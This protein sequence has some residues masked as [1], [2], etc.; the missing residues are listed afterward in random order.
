[1]AIR[2]ICW[3]SV[4][5]LT[6]QWAS[7]AGAVN[8]LR[9]AI[10][11]DDGWLTCFAGPGQEEMPGLF[12]PLW[13]PVRIPHNWETYQGYRRLSHGNLHGSAWYSRV[14]TPRPEDRGKRHFVEF[15]GVGSYATVWI[16][17]HRLGEHAGGR[18]G[19]SF[20]LTEHLRFGQPNLLAVHARHPEKIDDLPYVCG[21]CWGSPNTEGSQPLGI[22]RP[23]KLLV[24]APVRIEPLGVHVWTPQ[25]S[26]EEAVARVNT[27]V[28]NYGDA[29][30]S[31]T[32]RSEIVDADGT[33]LA[34]MEDAVN[35]ALG[36]MQCVEQ[37]SP[38]IADP[39]LWSLDDP[40]LHHV[41]STIVEDGAT[42]DGL[43]TRFG[44]RWIEWPVGSVGEGAV[45]RREIDPEKLAEEPS[46][47]N[48]FFTKVVSADE[49]APVGVEGA[50]RVTIP[51]CDPQSAVVRVKTTLTNRTDEPQ[52]VLLTS[53]I[54]NFAGT[55]FVYSMDEERTLAPGETHTF[56]QTS[57]AINFP[58]LWSPEKPYLHVLETT[59][60]HPDQAGTKRARVYARAETPFGIRAT[61]GLANKGDAYVADD[62]QAAADPAEARPFL[63]NGKPVFLNGTCEYEHLLGCDHAFT[64]EQIR[65]RMM[66][67]KAAGFNAFRD[68]HHPHNLRYLE[69]CDELG[70]LCWTQIG[71]HIYFDNEPFRD[72]YRRAV[73]EW[74]R[75]RRNSPSVALWGLQNESTLP[76]VFAREL[77]EIIRQMDPTTSG[78]RK[79]TTCNGG[80]GS[81]WDVPQNWLGTY[82]G[83]VNDYGTELVQQKLVGEYGQW[84]TFGLHQE[85]DWEENW[86]GNQMLG[87][88]IPEEL[89]TY[90]LETRVRLAEER[91][92]RVCGHF[93]W[94]F[95]THANP[96]RDL[97]NCRDGLPPNDV[98]VVN[99]K[100]LLTAWGEPV[101]AYY[102]F[103]ANYA[104]VQSE[105]MVYIH[106]HTW[107]DRF[108]GPGV[109]SNLVVYSNC[110]EVELFNDLGASSLGVRK[111]GPRGTHFEWDE[112]PIHYNVLYAEGRIDGET[113]ARDVIVLNN[114]PP[115]PLFEKGQQGRRRQHSPRSR[116]GVSLPD[117]LRRRAVHRHPRQHMGGRFALD[118]LGRGVRQPRPALRELRRNA[119]PHRRHPRRRAAAD[120]PL[121]PRQTALPLRGPQRPL[122]GGTLLHRTL[123]RHRRRHGLHRLAPVRRGR[124]WHRGARRPRPMERSRPRHGAQA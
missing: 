59:L 101:D 114:L 13:T 80:T 61:D 64:D 30:K 120:L 121:R 26:A 27:E 32:L 3:F 73:R 11:F 122:R 33:V 108:D 37:E 42:I 35:L 58:E 96:G 97:S 20:D 29:P 48:K 75:E 56:D 43:K 87:R 12:D 91:R 2:S 124:E 95:S 102:M 7:S 74:V 69:L 113:V 15:E 105:P 4:F 78:Q 93:Q 82:R 39:H 118:F 18:T 22:F 54:R 45:A 84:R 94:I 44:M 123:V 52:P 38:P 115:A 98:G 65:A 107:P 6:S 99:Y 111:R 76:E 10:S 119:R 103:R 25:I 109:K 86:A 88:V 24:T 104:P 85:G 5:M 16:N 17:G 53:F 31:I 34:Q 83:N 47:A 41:R 57:P 77:T 40:Y 90:S 67:I 49:Q 66:Q 55:K 28:K 100:G 60:Q 63:L 112:V 8:S 79:T 36:E 89:F 21:G 68:A 116:R 50:V 110:D 71:A 62:P 106:S 81:D 14:F 51:R 23:V 72:N 19:F 92:D 117:Q 46:A 9:Q 70:I 1:M